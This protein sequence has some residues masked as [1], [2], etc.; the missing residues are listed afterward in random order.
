MCTGIAALNTAAPKG[1]FSSAWLNQWHNRWQKGQ[2]K[3]GVAAEELQ[4]TAQWVL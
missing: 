1:K 3:Q 4:R 2:K